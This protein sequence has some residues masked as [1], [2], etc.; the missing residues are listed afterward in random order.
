MKEFAKFEILETPLDG[1]N[2]VEAS[3]GTGKTYAIVGMFIRLVVEQGLEVENILVVTFTEA[4]TQELKERIRSRV[5]DAIVAFSADSPA[6]DPMLANLVQKFN[7]RRETALARLNLALRFFDQAAIFTIHGFC[8]RLLRDHAFESG[9]LFDTELVTSQDALKQRIAEDFWRKHFSRA[10]RLFADYAVGEKKI[11]PHTLAGLLHGGVLMAA[12]KVLPEAGDNPDFRAAVADA[13]NRFCE[14]FA[15]L[16]EAWRRHRSDVAAILMDSPGLNRNKYRKASIPVWMAAMDHYAAMDKGTPVLFEKFEKFTA[17][18]VADGTKA[19]DTPEAHR[20]FDICEHHQALSGALVSFFNRRITRLKRDFIDYARR[21]LE[22]RKKRRNI[23]YFDDLVANVN[24]AL[25]ADGRG[26]LQQAARSRYRAVLIDEFQDTDPVQ[27][28]IFSRLFAGTTALFFIGDPKQAIYGFRGADIFAYLTA[29][30]RTDAAYTLDQNWRSARP[31]VHGVNALFT[32]MENPFVVEEIGFNPVVPAPAASI[33][34]LKQDGEVA[35]GIEIRF[36]H[37][38]AFDG[39]TRKDEWVQAVAADTAASIAGL[40]EK[41]RQGR[42]LLGDRPLCEADIAVLVRRH[43]EA[44]VVQR[45]LADLNINGII[46][47]TGNLF[48]SHEAFEMSVLLNAVLSPG[49]D[50]LVKAALATDMLGWSTAAIDALGRAD[51]AADDELASETTIFFECRD[52]WQRNG[53]IHM[54]NRMARHN[55]T[56]PRLMLFSD[57]ERRCTNLFHLAEVLHQTAVSGDLGPETLLKWLAK[58]RNPETRE[59]TEYP[60]RLESD[61]NA[62]S[63]ITIHKSKGLE[64]P[65]VFVPFLWGSTSRSGADNAVT[66]HDPSDG[67][68][69]TVDF[70]T[71]DEQCRQSID[72]ADKEAAAEAMRLTYVA[73]T[74]AKNYCCAAYVLAKA[75]GSPLSDLLTGSAADADVEARLQAIAS[76]A[77]ASGAAI[78]ASAAAPLNAKALHPISPAVESEHS[79]SCRAF[80]GNIHRDWRVLSFSF[81]SRQ[82]GRT[83]HFASESPISGMDDNRFLTDDTDVE[84]VDSGSGDQLL[85]DDERAGIVHF[86]KGAGAGL[87]MHEIFEH[88][89]F[90]DTDTARLEALVADGLARYNFDARWQPVVCGMVSR[91]LSVEMPSPAGG[92]SVRLSTVAAGQRIHELEFYFPLNRVSPAGIAGVYRGAGAV[93]PETEFAERLGRLTFSPARGFMKGFVDLVFHHEGRYYLA[94]WK[95]NFLGTRPSDY[96]RS[97]LYNEMVSACYLLQAHIYAVALNAYLRNRVPGYDYKSGFGGIFYIFLRGVDPAH[98]P[99]Y[100]IYRE[101]PSAELIEGLTDYFIQSDRTKGSLC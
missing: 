70:R 35:D 6:D 51:D 20:F 87:F 29:A 2:L 17:A 16:A 25:K 4:A 63:I 19:D 79:L 95:S 61:D 74:R 43:A 67:M 56:L 85:P 101:K 83:P 65:V 76:K 73:L 99:D 21:E 68:R 5:R 64:Y 47:K 57:G 53:F 45:C 50:R 97:A 92:K 8:N 31:L 75:A 30:G 78:Y 48:D 22:A 72:Q 54:F 34:A 88:L 9:I 52:L 42:S 40:L 23:H 71:G 37:A 12:V 98:G 80:A 27:Y 18:G 13:E 77:K 66:F 84:T 28:E 96:H 46:L 82:T 38:N 39:I 86:P 69:P 94:D 44:E 15:V 14:S 49:D 58:Q 24:A 62:V 3:A 55:R 41:G 32:A 26:L 60:L 33:P 93:P 1:V 91:V 89:A 11:F 81:M 90:T 36:F 7:N 10:S 100:G 59:T